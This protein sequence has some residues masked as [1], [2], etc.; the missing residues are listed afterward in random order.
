MKNAALDARLR[1]VAGLV[2]QGAVLAD[3]GTDHAF[4]PLFLLET[5]KIRRAVCTDINEGPLAKARENVG[6]AGKTDLCDFL[7]TDG[8]DALAGY[9]EVT[10]VAV[11]GMGGELI[12]GIVSRAKN[13]RN[14]ALSLILQPMTHPEVLRKTLA[15]CGFSVEKETYAVAA[16]KCYVILLAHYE[17]T[18]RVISRAEAALGTQV[19][20]PP[21][22]K[23]KIAY[24]RAKRSALERALRGKTRGG[25][26]TAYERELLNILDRMEE[27][28]RDCKD[29][30]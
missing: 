20:A 15:S 21:F 2:R 23:E 28:I 12:A 27:L 14:P 4:L 22:S 11:C 26:D 25:E 1:A 16:K 18:P 8:A 5:G 7:L 19:T 3:I 24:F 9:P 6:A 29:S 17:G 30:V 13:L 10:D